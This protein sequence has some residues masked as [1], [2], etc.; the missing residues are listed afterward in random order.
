MRCL[1]QTQGLSLF[2]GCLAWSH[3]NLWH[4]YFLSIFLLSRWFLFH[5][6]P[7]IDPII[8]ATRPQAKIVWLGSSATF[9]CSV[10]T[11]LG[12]A[13]SIT[14]WYEGLSNT[15]QLS[16]SADV[17][18]TSSTLTIKPVQEYRLGRY[19]CVARSLASSSNVTALLSSHGKYS[20]LHRILCSAFTE[21]VKFCHSLLRIGSVQKVTLFNVTTVYS[22][23]HFQFFT[24]IL[25]LNLGNTQL[26]VN[27]ESP[28][29]SPLSWH[30]SVK[31]YDS[32]PAHFF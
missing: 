25:F 28:P 4:S 9:A 12:A 17:Q 23:S 1:L 13:A 14:W 30:R 10:N 24:S 11:V 5:Y 21:S 27:L 20:G 2:D 16:A 22:Y 3:I 19:Y 29:T 32:D 26:S 15:A 8:F 7:T 6:F 18:I 31:S